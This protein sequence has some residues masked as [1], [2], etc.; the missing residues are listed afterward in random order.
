MLL[1]L[2]IG[3]LLLGVSDRN[4]YCLEADEVKPVA[5]VVIADDGACGGLGAKNSLISTE[6]SCGLGCILVID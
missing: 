2:V 3:L 6:I 4:Y 1:L 5:P